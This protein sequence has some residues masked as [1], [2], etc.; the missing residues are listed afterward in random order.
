MKA[1]CWAMK[2]AAPGQFMDKDSFN[3]WFIV[4]ADEPITE[5]VAELR[6][7]CREHPGFDLPP[8]RAQTEYSGICICVG[9]QPL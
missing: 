5:A 9:W 1:L 3:A 4:E 7:N 8:S 6:S 2:G